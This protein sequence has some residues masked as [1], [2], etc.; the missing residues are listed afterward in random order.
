M[1]RHRKNTY[2]QRPRSSRTPGGE[3]PSGGSSPLDYDISGSSG[4][5]HTH[6]SQTPPTHES[7][8]TYP[9][10]QE[11]PD[12]DCPYRYE[13]VGGAQWMGNPVMFINGPD[14]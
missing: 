5:S 14:K 10:F 12:D 4:T 7:V 8:S 9:E 3:G 11:I 2:G 13:I 1:P 6:V